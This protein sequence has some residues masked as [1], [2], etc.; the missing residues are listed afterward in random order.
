MSLKRKEYVLRKGMKNFIQNPAI[1]EG[2]ETNI[3][4]N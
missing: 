4:T 3:L 2:E 1:G